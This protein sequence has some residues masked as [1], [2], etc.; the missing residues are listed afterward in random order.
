MQDA[1]DLDNLEGVT[2][3]LNLVPVSLEGQLDTLLATRN[4][5]TSRPVTWDIL[6]TKL[7]S[8]R[9]TTPAPSFSRSTK[10]Y[11]H[12]NFHLLQRK[13]KQNENKISEH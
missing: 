5:T 8:R 9:N 7:V 1:N 6:Q 13:A 12:I 10:S 4:S 3:K 11:V 2:L